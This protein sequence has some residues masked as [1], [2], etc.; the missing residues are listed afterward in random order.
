[1][2]NERFQ[3]KKET[4]N[5][6]TFS[7]TPGLWSKRNIK[8]N[9]QFCINQEKQVVH[10]FSVPFFQKYNNANQ[11]MVCLMPK[12]VSKRVA[13][14]CAPVSQF[15]QNLTLTFARSEVTNDPAIQSKLILLIG[16][17]KEGRLFANVGTN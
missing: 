5:N 17:Q 10:A 13:V 4:F 16:M 11:Q 15:V 2:N 12:W 1:V 8:T 3:T 14:D 6:I 9:T 7:K